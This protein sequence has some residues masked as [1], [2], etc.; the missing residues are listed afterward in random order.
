VPEAPPLE[1]A[2]ELMLITYN[3]ADHLERTLG[4]IAAGPFGRCRLT[5]L[6][7][8]STDRTPDVCRAFAEGREHVRV[9]PHA[10]NLGVSPNYLRAV[11]L[12]TAPYTWVLADDD[13]W[14]YGDCDDVIAAIRAGDVDVISVGAPGQEA[15]ERGLRTT[16]QD[17]WRR[18]SRFFLTFSFIPSTIFRTELFGTTALSRGY[19]NA[20]ALY[21]HFPFL[22]E[23]L[24]ADRS[25]LVSKTEMVRRVHH[26]DLPSELFWMAAWTTSVAR[27]VADP[28]VRRRA[29]YEMRRDRREWL[30]LL[31]VSIAMEKLDHPERVERELLELYAGFARDQ[32]RWLALLAPLALVP[33][34]LLR[35]VRAVKLRLNRSPGGPRPFDQLRI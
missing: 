7:N 18:G 22:A 25:V 6:D 33:R 21:P 17:L 28:A 26:G 14:D 11:E 13:S 27:H 34:P 10:R 31:A 8:A 9:I 16:T 1:Q 3:R 23:L 32:R 2:L 29:I 35:A 24:E 4:E 19:R 30:G 5:I 15:W 12:A 20:D